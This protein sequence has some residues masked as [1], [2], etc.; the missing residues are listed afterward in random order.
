MLNTV[1]TLAGLSLLGI[2][3]PIFHS[4]NG[5]I[6]VLSAGFNVV[7]FYCR[8]RVRGGLRCR[9]TLRCSSQRL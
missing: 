7:S 1:L 4:Q 3:L 2:G 5:V 6:S 8:N 9:L